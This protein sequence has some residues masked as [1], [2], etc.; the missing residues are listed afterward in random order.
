[1]M[2]YLAGPK[3]PHGRERADDDDIPHQIVV[4]LERA[5]DTRGIEPYR[6]RIVELLSPRRI[7]ITWLRGLDPLRIVGFTVL[8][9]DGTVPVEEAMEVLRQQTWIEAVELNRPIEILAVND[10][11]YRQQWAPPRIFAPAAWTRE[12]QAQPVRVAIVDSGVATGHPDLQGHLA[13]GWNVLTWSADH[14]DHDGHGTL[15]AGTIGAVSNN[16]IGIAAAGWPIELLAVKFHDIRH[17]PNA[18]LA[19]VAIVWAI[20]VGRAKVINASWH[21]PGHP[22]AFLELVID[23]A[24]AHDVTVVAAA[25]N[26]GTDNDQLPTY[27]ASFSRVIAVMATKERD[28]KA[29]F[30]SYG[31]QSVH[32]AAPGVRI[33]STDVS[34]G[35]QPAR[36]RQYSGTSAACA[37]VAGAAA[38]LKA[39]NPLWTPQEI[40]Q[41]L[42]ASVDHMPTWPAPHLHCRAHGRVNL[43]KA[44]CGPLEIVSLTPGTIWIQGS[45]VTVTWKVTYDT[46]LCTSVAITLEDGSSTPLLLQKGIGV[47]SGGSWPLTMTWSGPVPNLPIGSPARVKIVSE[48]GPGLFDESDPISVI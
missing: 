1:M 40:R 36:W 35:N 12:S 14:E 41:H 4:T 25:G 9:R 45:S 47:P 11:L 2:S 28:G 13:G 16:G 37:L 39:L 5:A 19:A 26:D 27:P 20:F 22:L 6:E 30:S 8:P 32:L 23:Y 34:F 46:P 29:G 18:Y 7:A 21:V 44:V 38:F 17:R 42:I 31:E 43:E 24:W 3:V 10:P 15:L 33:L 48:Q